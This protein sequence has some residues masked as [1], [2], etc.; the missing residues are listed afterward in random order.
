MSIASLD[1]KI[2][3]WYQQ[4]M[5]NP[6]SHRNKIVK[7]LSTLNGKRYPFM[8]DSIIY[9]YKRIEF[10][11]EDGLYN[12]VPIVALFNKCPSQLKKLL[13]KN[14]VW[15]KLC[16]NTEERNK[17]IFFIGMIYSDFSI[18]SKLNI[19]SIIHDSPDFVL[20]ALLEKKDTSTNSQKKHILTL[21]KRWEK[22]I[23]QSNVPNKKLELMRRL[24]IWNDTKRMSSRHGFVFNNSERWKNIQRLHGQLSALDNARKVGVPSDVSFDLALKAQEVLKESDVC[25]GSDIEI[26]FLK[27]LTDY[28]IEKSSMKHCIMSYCKSAYDGNYLAAHVSSD[29]IEATLGIK[30][31]GKNKRKF[32]FEQIYGYGN[33]IISDLSVR[34]YVEQVIELLNTNFNKESKE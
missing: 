33:S 26:K 2:N 7:D 18:K 22:P 15:K 24:D 10:A 5:E 12:I 19:V 34:Q 29:V 23:A 31:I 14:G 28:S 1:K 4:I 16:K 30:V 13:S 9:A 25:K 11:Q 27:N 21:S 6:N 32:V 3:V 17:K 8:I 20:N